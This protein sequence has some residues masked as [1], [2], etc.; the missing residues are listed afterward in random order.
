[1]MGVTRRPRCGPSWAAVAIAAA[2]LAPGCKPETASTP[3]P[4]AA[5]P[6]A[7]EP[8][9]AESSA[10]SSSSAPEPAPSS[11]PS[12]PGPVAANCPNPAGAGAADTANPLSGPLLTALQAAGVT[13]IARYYDYPNETLPGKTLTLAERDLVAAKGMSL[14][15]VFQHH[16]DQLASFTAA[17]GDGDAARALELAA[18][19][20]Q[21]TGSAVY[22]GV[23]GSWSSAA[24][25]AKILAYFQAAHAR[26][27]GAGYRVGVYGSGLTCQNLEGAGQASLCWIAG[28]KSWPGY[29]AVMTSG[30]WAL[31]QSNQVLCAG[32]YVDFDEVNP[33]RPD[34]GQFMP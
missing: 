9:P 20:G 1:M 28:V 19:M 21:P 17:R 10:P 31:R 24:D 25:Q 26:L 18:K 7:I 8:A 22:F 12:P 33:A 34:A 4:S 23:D 13:T 5:P 27:A 16:N 30:G 11:S 2:L 6:S 14:I 3:A 29:D 15:V 32:T